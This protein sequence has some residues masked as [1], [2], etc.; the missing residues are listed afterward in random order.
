M[1]Q[2]P[3]SVL[4]IW[5]LAG[6]IMQVNN[7][8]K[9]ERVADYRTIDWKGTRLTARPAGWRRWIPYLRRWP[10]FTG[11][12]PYFI[13]K[14]EATTPERRETPGRL[15][16]HVPHP[17]GGG[18]EESEEF[19]SLQRPVTVK[20]KAPW[21]YKTGACSV[22]FDLRLVRGSGQSPDRKAD[23]IANFDVKSSDTLFLIL[24]GLTVTAIISL[25]TAVVGPVI[26][27]KLLD[28]SPQPV[29]V[30][31]ETPPASQSGTDRNEP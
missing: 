25:M 13:V 30:V 8:P 14:V 31:T 10:F 18:T 21:L 15:T 11:C 3:L 16:I 5:S 6:G 27:D 28:D 26:V 29:I 20:V 12:E 7:P 19:K 4:H 2:Y 24:V 22:D 17:A 23:V 1:T 9:G